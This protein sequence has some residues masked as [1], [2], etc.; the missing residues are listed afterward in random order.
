MTGTVER[1]DARSAH[2]GVGQRIERHLRERKRRRWHID[3]LLEEAE[4]ISTIRVATERKT[5]ECD[6]A[7][8]LLRSE[9]ATM[10]D[11]GFGSSDCRC[12]SHLIFFGDGGGERM[13]ESIAMQLGLLSCVSPRFV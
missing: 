13:V 5:D 6:V 9:G 3:Y 2:V 1:A 11:R 12:D 4:V 7:H 8:A 10:V